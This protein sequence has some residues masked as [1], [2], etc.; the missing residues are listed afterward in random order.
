MS[1][2]CRHAASPFFSDDLA[3][4]RLAQ[5]RHLPVS[6]T[7]GLLLYLIHNKAVSVTEV[8]QL[9]A[10]MKAQGYRAPVESLQIYIEA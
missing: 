4:R 5:A 8:D 3:A 7:I 9:L 2:C 1:G 10:M 6:G